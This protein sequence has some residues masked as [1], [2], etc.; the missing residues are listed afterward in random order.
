MTKKKMV[1]L[2]VT[3]SIA[4]YKTPESARRLV[5]KNIDVRV[6]M[7]KEAEHFVTTLTLQ[8]VSQHKVYR[9]MFG[10][11]D[12]WD[13]EHVA[14]AESADL[15]LIAPATAHII[16]KLAAGLCDDFLSCV[17]V[18]TKAQVVLAPAMNDQMYQHKITQDN[19]ARLKKIGYKFIGPEK[20]CLACGKMAVGRMSAVTDIV[21]QAL[22]FLR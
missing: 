11:S 15:V 6:M 4:A 1:L 14:L 16:A 3:G 12:T 10:V 7:T 8:T 21:Q 19:I 17:V 18:A 9:D 20:G 22:R 5:E 2:G 13:V